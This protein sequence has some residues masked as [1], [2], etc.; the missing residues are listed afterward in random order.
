MRN[1]C[2]N[3][4]GAGH[5]G[6]LRSHAPHRATDVPYFNINYKF[7]GLPTVVSDSNHNWS[8]TMDFTATLFI[9]SHSH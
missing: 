8:H 6:S 4:W 3:T 2:E 5:T 7:C 1:S 9:V